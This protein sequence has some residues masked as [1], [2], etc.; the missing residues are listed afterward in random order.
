MRAKI[1]VETLLQI[2]LILVV[3][4]LAL[5]II[6]AT[7]GIL[8]TLLAPLSGVFGLII[9]IVIILWLLDYI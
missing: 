8:G 5:Q 6:D 3:I 9:L 4:W 7:L 2:I 1:E